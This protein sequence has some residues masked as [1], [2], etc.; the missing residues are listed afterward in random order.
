MQ[1]SLPGNN[2]N[3]PMFKKRVPLALIEAVS[4]L[5][6]YLSCLPISIGTG[7][8]Q[9]LFQSCNWILRHFYIC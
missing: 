1:M 3:F 2:N 8:V 5:P 4:K 7:D 6:V 9:F